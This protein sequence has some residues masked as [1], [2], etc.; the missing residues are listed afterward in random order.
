MFVQWA[1]LGN[2][3]D[4]YLIEH[5]FSFLKQECL[6]FI[7]WNDRTFE[8]VYQ[9][10]KKYYKWFNN[11]RIYKNSNNKLVANK[12]VYNTKESGQNLIA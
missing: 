5:H 11:E 1:R 2:S 4:N 3:L 7:K 12:L 8:N 6:N 9:N 10:V